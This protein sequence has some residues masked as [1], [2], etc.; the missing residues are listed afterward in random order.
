MVTKALAAGL[1]AGQ[2]E[3]AQMEVRVR[4]A[5]QSE[6]YGFWH[7]VT[8]GHYAHTAYPSV[9]CGH[10]PDVLQML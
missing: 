2:D 5:L 7:R 8:R 1:V 6:N 10:V 9:R 4:T 3:D